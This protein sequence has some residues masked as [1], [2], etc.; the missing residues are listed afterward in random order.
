MPN[1]IY[2]LTHELWS[3]YISQNG[4]SSSH[5]KTL[6]SRLYRKQNLRDSSA[7]NPLPQKLVEKMEQDF[8]FGLPEIHSYAVSKYD[9]SIKFI[10]EMKDKSLVETVLMPETSRLTLCLSSQVGCRQACSFCH[11][12]RMGLKRNLYVHEIIGQILRIQNWLKTHP[13]WLMENQLSPSQGVSNIVFMGMGEPLDN[14]EHVANAVKIMKDP[15]GLNI[16]PK[17]IT[18]STAG[19]LEGLKTFLSLNL[20]VALALS[21]HT[22]NP[23]LRSQLMP[24]NRRYPIQDVLKFL[25]NKY[26][27]QKKKPLIQYTLI[28]GVNDSLQDAKDL[29]TLIKPLNPKVN[30]IPMNTFEESSFRPPDSKSLKSFQNY[31]SKNSIRSMIRFSKGQD[32]SAGCGQLVTQLSS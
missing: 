24:I 11:T 25:E 20:G 18:V 30:L 23:S 10:I 8:V 13:S 12:G 5:L 19:H 6:L 1:N 26:L 28:S 32:I 27:G 21:L 9:R 16:A 29:V 17:R 22:S 2:D 31:L 14:I 4:F 3:Q 15:F 7:T